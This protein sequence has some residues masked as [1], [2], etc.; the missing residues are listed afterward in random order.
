M[1]LKKGSSE[2]DISANIAE[3]V[4]A[5]HPQKQAEAIAYRV[6]GQDVAVDMSAQQWNEL[7]SLFGKWINE[8]KEEPEHADD[9]DKLSGKEKSEAD[10]DHDEREDQPASA[11]LEPESRKYPV[12]VKRGGKWEYDKDLLVAAAR[13]ARMHD[14]AELASKADTIRKREFEGASDLLPPGVERAP[15]E[16]LAVDRASVRRIDQDGKLYVEISAISKANVCPYYG[17]E[18]PGAADLGLDPNKVYM[19]LRDPDE[20]AKAAPTFNGI[21]LLSQH[22]PFSASNPPK[23]YVVGATGNIAMYEAPYLKNGLVVWDQSAIAG[24][25]SG[26]QRELSSSYRYVPDMTPGEYEGVPYDGRM[27][28]IVGNHVA[29]VEVGRAGADVLVGDSQPTELP[30]KLNATTVAMRA[31]LG[32]YLR[33]RLAQ[34]SALLNK[35]PAIIKG[36]KRPDF[37]AM[38]AKSVFD[39]QGIDFEELQSV[40]QAAFD[41][42]K[43]DSDDPEAEDE[44]DE[45]DKDKASDE[46]KEDDK[47]KKADDEDEDDKDGGKAMDADSIRAAARAEYRAL[48]EAE[49]AVKPLVGEVAAMDSAEDV[50]R[51]ALDQAGVDHKGV[52]V[53]AL[54]ALVKMAANASSNTKST[55]AAMDAS[56]DDDFSKRF[57]GAS[58]IRRG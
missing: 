56:G 12:K 13:E 54:P 38:D 14:H 49:H 25:E 16:R 48:R 29:L 34:D 37:I 17:R 23:E 30:M 52:H 50:Y 47:D 42:A 5:G 58:H 55:T 57:P 51:F 53:S 32:A 4:N 43:A 26:E 24:I 8:E 15:V 11:F 20:L 39:G 18:I 21:P 9:S 31:A 28:Q 2:S 36:N 44:D 46:D 33:P 45:D 7:L 19:L 10:K 27:T 41:E 1:P 3:L 6:A 35:I 22:I 40:L